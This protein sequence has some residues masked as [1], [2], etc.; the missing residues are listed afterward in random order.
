MACGGGAAAVR[1][2]SPE[3]ADAGPVVVERTDARPPDRCG[4]YRV[5]VGPVL[6]RIERSAEAFLHA[7]DGARD[8]ASVARAAQVLSVSLDGELPALDSIHT[9]DA[10]LD[11][12]HARLSSALAGLSS[13]V[14]DLGAAYAGSG[15]G[16]QPARESAARVMDGAIQSWTDAVRGV[17]VVCP[18]LE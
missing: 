9:T 2:Q 10:E 12:A 13:A 16:A 5:A 17:L 11:A 6:G 15:G 8:P 3:A 1:L 18:G 14:R 7:L 4:G